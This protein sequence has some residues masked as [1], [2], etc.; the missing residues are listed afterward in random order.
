MANGKGAKP[1]GS[2]ALTAADRPSSNND[3]GVPGSVALAIFVSCAVHDA[4]GLRAEAASR[5]EKL[6]LLQITLRPE[7]RRT[8]H[9][10]M[11]PTLETPAFASRTSPHSCGFASPS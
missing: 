1:P 6:S 8:C 9:P 3:G 2:S 10:F 5:R 11:H 7:R 4:G